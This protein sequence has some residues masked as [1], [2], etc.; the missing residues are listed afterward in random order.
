MCAMD[1]DWKHVA[2]QLARGDGTYHLLTTPER[3]ALEAAMQ[4]APP[5]DPMMPA[6]DAMNLLERERQ[7][8]DWVPGFGPIPGSS[9]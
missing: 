4:A 6:R 2:V 8:P 5:S 9:M 7:D 1:I 3:D